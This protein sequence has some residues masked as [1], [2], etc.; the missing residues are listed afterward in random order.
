METYSSAAISPIKKKPGNLKKEL[1]L[2][3]EELCKDSQDDSFLE[4]DPLKFPRKYSNK[5]DIEISAFF[6]ALMAWGKRAI[7][8]NK[9]E[10][11][12]GRMQ[13]SPYEFVMRYT[14]R[15]NNLGAIAGFKHR[16]YKDKQVAGIIL[17]LKSA[18]EKY[19]NL[20]S[21]FKEGLNMAEAQGIND[22]GY[23][24]LKF[25]IG[26]FVEM[27]KKFSSSAGFPLSNRHL[28]SPLQ[29]ESACKRMNLFLRWMVRKDGF[30][31]GIWNCLQPGSLLVPLDLVVGRAGQCLGLSE[32]KAPNKWATAVQITESLKLFDVKDPTRFDF[33]LSQIGCGPE[34]SFQACRKCRF[35][36]IADMVKTA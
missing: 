30:D 25:A 3:L 16:T 6:S 15:R 24:R 9:L 4:N 26:H 2:L 32:K 34:G 29:G 19:D 11:L 35:V 8:L 14:V 27:L 31:L 21:L 22:D 17:A 18:I 36:E 28:P 20:E 1:G 23:M 12:F 7:I 10:D 13:P 5:L 33:A